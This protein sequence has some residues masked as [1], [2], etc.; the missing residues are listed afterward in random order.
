[1]PKVPERIISY[2]EMKENERIKANEARRSIRRP[3][4]APK[5]S[6]SYNSHFNPSFTRGL[7]YGAT[8]A[9][10]KRILDN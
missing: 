2:G 4:E 10:I 6:K 3:K 9:E 8:E 1:M 7:A 5:T